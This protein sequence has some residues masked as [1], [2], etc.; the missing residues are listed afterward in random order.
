MTRSNEEVST[1]KRMT[2]LNIEEAREILN[3]KVDRHNLQLPAARRL[4]TLGATPQEIKESLL[5]HEN[6]GVRL[7]AL[8]SLGKHEELTIE[9]RSEW[10]AAWKK[11]ISRMNSRK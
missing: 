4:V 7:I 6:L 1:L 11:E 5:E 2:S 8:N 9:E 3:Q 10:Q